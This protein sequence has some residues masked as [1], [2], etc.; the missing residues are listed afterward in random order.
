[1]KPILRA[2]VQSQD[3]R[4][5]LLACEENVT[6]RITA[7]RPDLVRVTLLR[8]G[9]LRQNRSWSTLPDGERDAEW[10]GRD[11]LDDSL[12]PPIPMEI[13]QTDAEATLRTEAMRLTIALNGL[14]MDWSLPDGTVFARDRE[15]QPYFLG[16]KTHAFRHAMARRA[17]DRYYG[18]GDKTGALDLNGRRVRLA[19]RD[20]LG[21]NPQN[22]DPLY[23][24]WPFLIVRDGP[25]AVSYGLFYDNYSEASF[26]LGCERDNYFGPYRS[27]EAEDG[28]LDFYL[29]LGPR[30]KDVTPKFLA[31][32]GRTALPPRWSLGFAQ[33]AMGLADSP[34][35]QRQIQ[36]VIEKAIAHDIP[37]SAFHFGS[38]YTSIGAKRYVFNWNFAKFPEPKA[39]M[40]NFAEAGVRVVA[41]IK[42]CLL[43]DHPRYEEV[44]ALGGFITGEADKTPLKSQFWDG[45]GAHLDFT[46]PA[47]IRWWREGLTAQ[48]L[49]YG[50]DAGWCDNNEYGLW[51]DTATC[52]SFGEPTPLSL[53]RPV[54]ALLMTRA[55]REAQ[56]AARPNER[57][58]TVTRGGCPGI[59][60][61][62]Q[63]WSGDNTT[64]WESLK[65][66]LRTGLGMSLSGML[67]VGHDIGGF[68]GPVPGP[69]LLIRWT[70]A[71]VLHPRFIMNSWKP[72]NVTTSPWLHPEA[73][74]AIREALRLRL[75]LMP[76]LY[77]AM[78][79]A[80][81]THRP[82][83][84]PTFV[85]FEH[86]PACFA[87]CDAFM[88]GPSL[89]AAPVT[90]EGAHEVA[91]YLP[92]GPDWWYDFS[93]GETYAPGQI[94][95]IAAPLERLPLLAPSGAIVPVTDSRG[96]YARRHDEPS[97]ALRLFP[98]RS[99]GRS[100][101]I[102]YEDDGVSANGPLTEVTINLAW[103]PAEIHVDVSVNGDYPLPYR[104]MR[105]ILP[106]NENRT[107]KLAVGEAKGH[108]ANR[109]ALV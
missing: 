102:L 90:A 104:E 20:S 13:T 14:R 57:P 47:A 27:Y 71:G 32:T 97:R 61:Y 6:I 4:G 64:S 2:R 55:T 101:T 21:Y 58:F 98:G 44:A 103:T 53:V 17:G 107:L 42:P 69:E 49:G 9:R 29:F 54:Q 86:D 33:T 36:G 63:T 22:G 24:N 93:S 108:A 62:A 11:R 48:V 18:A 12:W 89:M 28:D 87:D 38:G 67:N 70:Q 94:V 81:R 100:S 23:K 25:S 56:I 88:F 78:Q 30:L 35:A 96:D 1:M 68:A 73:L 50:V 106:H 37:L 77:S 95:T 105:I 16:Q 45:E 109:I 7:L 10:A 52:A 75:Q 66:N 15:T 84:T 76:Y 79:A 31:L 65:W 19:M 5:L 46:N 60:R 40:R 34:D 85:P 92:I 51:D 26:D 72:D 74:P 80:Y 91:V 83:L 43:D 41:N 39:L 8:N 59:Q 3:Q 82:V 99:S